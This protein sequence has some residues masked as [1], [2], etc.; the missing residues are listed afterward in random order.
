MT[1]NKFVSLAIDAA[2]KLF[3]LGIMLSL[4]YQILKPFIMPVLWAIIIAV[5]FSPLITK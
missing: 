5:A 1:D 2:I 4:S 3:L